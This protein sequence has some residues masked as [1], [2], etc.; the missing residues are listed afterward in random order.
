[1]VLRRELLLILVLPWTPAAPPPPQSL[2]PPAAASWRYVASADFDGIGNSTAWDYNTAPGDDGV[3]SF[4]AHPN[5][6]VDEDWAFLVDRSF[7]AGFKASFSYRWARTTDP[8]GSANE[9]GA[10]SF[11]FGA[12]SAADFYAIDFPGLAHMF[13]GGNV[14]AMISHVTADGVRT[15]LRQELLKEVTAEPGVWHAVTVRLRP[16]AGDAP[17]ALLV[18]VDGAPL[19]PMEHGSL[20]RD[21]SRMDL[22]P[23]SS[24]TGFVGFSSNNYDGE[25]AKGRFSNFSISGGV[26]PP[27][28][29]WSD[30]LPLRNWANLG[31]HSRS[32]ADVMSVDTVVAATDGS[33]VIKAG[34]WGGAETGA[35]FR[36]I[37][38]GRHWTKD[39][40]PFLP[41]HGPGTTVVARRN[42]WNGSTIGLEM[43]RL[44]TEGEG[45][46]GETDTRQLEV[47]RS[48]DDGHTWPYPTP[49]ANFT[50]PTAWLADAKQADASIE[51]EISSSPR[52]FRDPSSSTGSV[53]VWILQVTWK[54]IV[55]RPKAAKF[56]N[57]TYGR[58]GPQLVSYNACVRSVDGVTW[59]GMVRLDSVPFPKILQSDT[60]VRNWGSE[61]Y[62]TQAQGAGIVAT[63][64]ND[65]SPTAWF[66]RSLDGARCSPPPPPTSLSPSAPRA[67]PP[68]RAALPMFCAP[69]TSALRA[70]RAAG[71]S[72]APLS[73]APFYACA[74]ATVTTAS[75]VMLMGGRGD[76][77]T[78]AASFDDGAT[79]QLFVIEAGIGLGCTI[80]VRAVLLG[81]FILY[82]LTY[83]VAL[84]LKRQCD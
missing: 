76:G 7:P 35:F 10:A 4:T 58:S 45:A 54:P 49:V 12:A 31:H 69:L 77:L 71:R 56:D 64:R 37:D 26:S 61:V 66:T 51:L 29:P 74:A 47:S 28:T 13:L 75:G 24:R 79:W 65:N 42:S 40:K 62:A 33:L 63:I 82:S 16:A 84:F 78:V 22:S 3:L 59:E 83:S 11:L 21:G 34:N 72:W 68:G 32:G 70:L 36:S 57:I 48:P 41:F 55:P 8:G 38:Q 30:E 44:F 80:A 1:M 6:H 19:F 9:I 18:A 60:Q 23:L 67:P 15:V 53:W 50:I 46:R 17:L 73:R 25:K 52:Q 39:A 5:L 2:F 20:Q 43:W 27:A 81:H 14:W